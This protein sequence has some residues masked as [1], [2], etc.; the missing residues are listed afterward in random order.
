MYGF[1]SCPY[2]RKIYNYGKIISER[3][4]LRNCSYC[5]KKFLVNKTV[6][7][8]TVLCVCIILI[9]I[10][11]LIMLLSQELKTNTFKMMVISDALAITAAFVISPFLVRFKAVNDTADKVQMIMRQ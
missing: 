6:K 3:G 5:H 8:I 2:C 7:H 9:I 1:R 4:K 11:V 10:N